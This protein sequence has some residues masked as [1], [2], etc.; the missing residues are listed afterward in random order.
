MRDR[1][2]HQRG[3]VGDDRSRQVQEDRAVVADVQ[4]LVPDAHR[5]QPIPEARRSSSRSPSPWS[6]WQWNN[7]RMAS[8]IPSGRMLCSDG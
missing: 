8:F 7:E 1:Q 4:A 6:E 5:I 2:F 3:Q